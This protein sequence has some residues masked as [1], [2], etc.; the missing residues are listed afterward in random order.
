MQVYLMQHAEAKPEEVDPDRSLSEK[1][2]NDIEAVAARASQLQV[3]VEEIR[4]SG[5]LRAQQTAD[6]LGDALKPVQGVN[7]GSGLGPVDDVKPVAKALD[8]ES[9]SL[10]LVGHLPFMARIAGLLVAGDIEVPA[11]K[12]HNAALVCLEKKDQYWQ[13]S[14]ILTPEMAKV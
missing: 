4:H 1:G 11:V 14:W 3:E 12:I 6:I 10:V 9:S 13:V 5:K 2:R 8:S 7:K